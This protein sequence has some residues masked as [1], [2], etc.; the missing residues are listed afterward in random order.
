MTILGSCF[1]MGPV[2]GVL[3]AGHHSPSF[4]QAPFQDS[5]QFD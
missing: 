5:T 4:M 3:A 1:A 2:Q